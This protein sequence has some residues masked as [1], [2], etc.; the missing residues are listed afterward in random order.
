TEFGGGR[1]QLGLG[2]APARPPIHV[3]QGCTLIGWD[4][5]DPNDFFTWDVNCWDPNTHN[6]DED[7]NFVGG[8]YLDQPV[9]GRD[10]YSPC[11]DAG[12]D[13]ASNLGMDTY[14][15]RIDGV[16][17]VNVVDMGYHYDNEGLPQYH[18]TVTVLEDPNDP[19]IHG[20]VE[21]NSS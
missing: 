13:L 8:Y 4:P 6:I 3:E 7:P 10:G 19:G 16:N 20:S 5:N 21:P 2:G 15:T 14:N 9:F 11:V 12:S 17:D 1:L 18:L